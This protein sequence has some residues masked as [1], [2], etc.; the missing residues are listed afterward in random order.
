[1]RSGTG[2]LAEIITQGPDYGRCNQGRGE[3]ILVEFVSANPTGPLHLGHGRGAALGDS[4]CRLLDFCG[5]AVS[6]EFYINDAGLQIRLLGESIYSR[7]KQKRDPEVPF[8][9][10]GYR[11]PYIDDLA[12]ALE[13]ES[14]LAGMD[15]EEAV[16]LCAA[17]GR[18]RM[19]DEIRSDLEAFGTTFDVWFSE[20]DLITSG[21]LDKE[22]QKI[23]ERGEFY[24][25]DGAW[26]IRDHRVRVTTRTV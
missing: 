5:Y 14:D 13:G 7:W 23:R 11:G 9:E 22:L 19:L 17:F 1:M 25:K 10:G 21:L 12:T 26:W 6:R 3:S 4:L 20:K 8:P 2:V 16:E 15:P 24:E 18:R